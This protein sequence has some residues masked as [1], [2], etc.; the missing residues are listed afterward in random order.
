MLHPFPTS[1]NTAPVLSSGS[2]GGLHP[3]T[4][5]H[6]LRPKQHGS[7][8]RL[9]SAGPGPPEASQGQVW[10]MREGERML[11]WSRL[12]TC[13][14]GPLGE[15]GSPAASVTPGDRHGT[16]H[17]RHWTGRRDPAEP[18]GVS[19]ELV[20][21]SS[22][23]EPVPFTWSLLSPEP[24]AGQ[25]LRPQIREEEPGREKAVTM[26][27]SSGRDRGMCPVELGAPQPPPSPFPLL[28][29]S[30]GNVV[31]QKKGEHASLCPS[32]S[33]DTRSFVPP[34]LE[35]WDT[36]MDFGN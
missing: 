1:D 12:K 3:T 5:D 9:Q 6:A 36:C 26:Y 34:S 32:T 18:Q 17:K 4:G 28:H 14:K 10:V 20:A 33:L 35:W 8:R 25:G 30:P 19:S 11:G 21:P 2:P 24:T 13:P 15:Q 27:R 22:T 31:G 7:T 16:C 23:R 29:P